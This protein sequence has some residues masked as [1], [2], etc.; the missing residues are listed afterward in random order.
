MQQPDCSAIHTNMPAWFRQIDKA[1]SPVAG[2][3]AVFRPT[4]DRIRA[5]ATLYTKG[6]AYGYHMGSSADAV[7]NRDSPVGLAAYF[8]DHDMWET[9]R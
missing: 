7:R 5:T 8:L 3:V 6:V 4:R 9:T 1:L 2:P